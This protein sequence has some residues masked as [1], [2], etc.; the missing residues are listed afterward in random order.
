[1]EE[2]L[3]SWLGK[4]KKK[5]P[6]LDFNRQV[7]MEMMKR[8]GEAWKRTGPNNKICGAIKESARYDKREHWPVLT[9]IKGVCGQCKSRCCIVLCSTILYCTIQV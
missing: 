8:H 5:M 4:K 2:R 9:E 6:F 1:M 7:V 3:V